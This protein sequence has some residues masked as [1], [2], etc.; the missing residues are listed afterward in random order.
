MVWIVLVTLII[1]AA[2]VSLG[3]VL[4]LDSGWYAVF[5]VYGFAL[6]S[7]TVIGVAVVLGMQGSY[8]MCWC[9]SESC[10]IW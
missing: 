7:L 9:P 2:N 10:R 3:W 4:W 1:I 5:F 6:I 8:E